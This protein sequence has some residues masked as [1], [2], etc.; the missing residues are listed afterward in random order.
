MTTTVSDYLGKLAKQHRY[1]PNLVAYLTALVKPLVDGKS[2]AESLIGL[3]DVDTATGEQLDMIGEWVG[4]SRNL[5][6]AITGVYF[7]WDTDGVGWDQGIWWQVGDSLTNLYVLPDEQYRLLLKAKIA[8]NSWDGTS[9][10]ATEIWNTLFDGN[11]GIIIIDNQDMTIDIM[12][13]GDS[14]D[15]VGL[16]LLTSG[17][18][19]LKAAGVGV[20]Q[21]IV[22]SA[23]GPLFGLDLDNDAISGLDVGTIAQKVTV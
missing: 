9:S 15:A 3:F 16:A 17:V 20:N 14:L 23:N 1:K 12:V 6:S 13:Y 10:S 21:Y 4:T 7:A 18:L 8:A 19:D 11:Q 2:V 5:K 22:P